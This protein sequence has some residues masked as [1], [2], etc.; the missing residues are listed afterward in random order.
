M[1]DKAAQQ[2]IYTGPY[3]T[4]KNLVDTSKPIRCGNKDQTGCT[5]IMKPNGERIPFTNPVRV[6]VVCDRCGSKCSVYQGRG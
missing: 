6:V 1:N 5:G 4:Q 2:E 3:S